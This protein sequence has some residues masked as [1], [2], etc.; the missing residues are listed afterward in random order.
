M[1]KES[2]SFPLLSF[3]GQAKPNQGF[4]G[5]IGVSEKYRGTIS[6]DDELIVAIRSRARDERQTQ[7][8]I[9]FTFAWLTG[10]HKRLGRVIAFAFELP[11]SVYFLSRIGMMDR[12][13]DVI[14][15]G[16]TLVAEVA[17]SLLFLDGVW[18]LLPTE[19]LGISPTALVAADFAVFEIPVLIF[20][21]VREEF[22]EFG[23]PIARKNFNPEIVFNFLQ[24]CHLH[25]F[26]A[27]N[28]EHSCPQLVQRLKQKLQQRIFGLFISIS[29]QSE[30]L[31]MSGQSEAL[32]ALGGQTAIALGLQQIQSQAEVLGMIEAATKSIKDKAVADQMMATLASVREN[33]S[34]DTRQVQREL[35]RQLM[36]SMA[37][38]AT[39]LAAQP[40]K[41]TLDLLG[42]MVGGLSYLAPDQTS[43]KLV[44]LVKS[45]LS[46]TSAAVDATPDAIS[47][48]LQG[49]I[50]TESWVRNLITA[51][52][53][54]SKSNH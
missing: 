20:G 2:F 50:A 51:P 31:M 29:R 3:D 23:T 12:T 26:L 21:K 27:V 42:S 17:G 18:E 37:T 13:T 35:D 39:N 16:T 46:Q 15:G 11:P 49:G 41:L 25:D 28:H 54:R 5:A 43:S 7:L 14:V 4:L 10:Q 34:V 19:D 8:L 30:G 45:G 40:V 36:S 38:E 47:K 48:M 44:L 53:R 52:W 6:E 24:L 33:M 22:G 1:S 9:S 32:A